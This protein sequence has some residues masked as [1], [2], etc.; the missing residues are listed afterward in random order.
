M[1][2]N[3]L[4]AA[5]MIVPLLLGTIVLG[6][7]S[8]PASASVGCSTSTYDLVKN[9]RLKYQGKTIGDRLFV[10][11]SKSNKKNYCFAIT[12]KGGAKPITYTKRTFKKV[13]GTWKSVDFNKSG[14]RK[15]T[16][17]ASG[18]NVGKNQKVVLKAYVKNYSKQYRTGVFLY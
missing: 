14:P 13:N 10:Y 8:T 6:T 7:A 16:S 2:Y 11:Q 12:T 4:L 1:R 15:T 17:I 9:K 3:R 18:A 5:I